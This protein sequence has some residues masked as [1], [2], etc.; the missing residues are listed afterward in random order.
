MIH[1][2]VIGLGV[3]GTTHLDA[4]AKRDDVCV[5][6]VADADPRKLSGGNAGE[7]NVE[8]QAQGG[9]DL[10]Q[11]KPY[12]EGKDLIADPDVQLVDICLP[13]HMHMDYA[14]ASLEAGKHLLVEKPLARTYADAKAIADAGQRASGLSMPAMCM[15]FWPGWSWLKE[16]IEKQT[17]GKVYAAHFRRVGS[18][19]GG[20]FYSDGDLSGGA[21]LDLHIH[22]AD[23]VHYCFGMPKAVYSRGYSKLT[24]ALDHVVTQYLYDDGPVVFA[25]GGWTMAKGFG[26]RMQYTVNFERATAEFSYDGANHVRL[27]EPGKEPCEVQL[28]QGLGYDHQAAYLLDCIKQGRPPALVTLSQAAESI[29]LV[30]AEQ[31]SALECKAVEL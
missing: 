19:P 24:H 17:Y 20:A 21:I 1:V 26:F 28:P 9:A 11:A 15:R 27:C 13:T 3:M 6:A 22:D 12:T 31:R 10:S 30:E 25:E 23:F 7:G 8:G 4:Y 16:A 2:G 18:H 29:R 5:T 14:V